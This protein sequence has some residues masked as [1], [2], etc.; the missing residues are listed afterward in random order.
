MINTHGLT[1][2]LDHLQEASDATCRWPAGS[3]G[4]TDIFYDRGTGDVWAVDL[5]GQNRMDYNDP[6]II[7]VCSTVE[8]H[9]PQWIADQIAEAVAI[10]EEAGV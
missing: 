7:K 9:T 3:G 1:I 10:C 4:R 8:R 2:N 5:I 6:S